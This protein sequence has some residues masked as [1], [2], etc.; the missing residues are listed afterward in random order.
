MQLSTL[1]VDEG[2]D[3]GDLSELPRDLL[4]LSRRADL[5]SFRD[6]ELFDPV[7]DLVRPEELAEE[8]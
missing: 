6:D 3:R 4:Q 2:V 1:A 5:T 7:V 8:S